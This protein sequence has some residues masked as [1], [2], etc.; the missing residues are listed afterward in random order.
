MRAVVVSVVIGLLTAA[1]LFLLWETRAV[2]EVAGNNEAAA[3]QAAAD[4]ERLTRQLAAESRVRRAAQADVVRLEGEVARTAAQ[5]GKMA[6]VV[7]ATKE[8]AE[9]RAAA[10]RAAEL[11]AL[12]A[13]PAGVRQCLAALHG[14][15]L[16][17]GYGG[18]R[19]LRA[20]SLDEDGLHDVEVIQTHADGLGA[21]LVV[22]ATMTALLDRSAQRLVFTFVDGSRTSAGQRFELPEEGWTIVFDP[23]DGRLIEQRLPQLVKAEGVY[24]RDREAPRQT[25]PTDVDPATR[26][27]WLERFD[28]LLDAAGTADRVRVQHFRGLEDG[29][30]LEAR[31]LATDARGHVA[32]GASCDRLAVEID[33]E[34]GVVSLVMRDGLL[35]RGQAESTI[36]AEGYRML[37]PAVKPDRAIELMLGLVVER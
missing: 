16:A 32:F 22:A 3:R 20:R 8:R 35:R 6:D 10:A 34:A 11:R 30:F 26:V 12:R 2:A 24:P 36:T 18:V 7:Q 19:F 5:L 1:A 14:C 27:A 25:R 9:R 13:M 21:D 15:L 28:L 4:A 17:E 37:L 33:R 29:T 31:L 23:V